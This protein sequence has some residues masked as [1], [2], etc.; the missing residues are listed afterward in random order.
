MPYVNAEAAGPDEIRA[1]AS[2]RRLSWTASCKPHPGTTRL[3]GDTA[4]GR[5]CIQEFIRLRDGRSEMPSMCSQA[6]DVGG[7]Q[8][9]GCGVPFRVGL[10]G[11]SE[12]RSEGDDI[13]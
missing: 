4:S 9:A 7:E 10:P 12:H 8:A 11:L 13:T 6:I 2:G 3:D 1:W 5:A